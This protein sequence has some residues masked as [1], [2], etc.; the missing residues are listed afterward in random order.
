VTVHYGQRYFTAKE[1]DAVAVRCKATTVLRMF[2]RWGAAIDA[3]GLV[4]RPYEKPRIDKISEHDLFVELERI[5]KLRGHRPSQ[6][7]WE[8]SSPRLWYTT[9]T[10]R[11]G[12]WRNAC[13]RIIKSKSGLS[14]FAATN[15]SEA[16][17]VPPSAGTADTKAPK[18]RK[19]DIPLRIRLRVI[20]RDG[21]RCVACGRSPAIEAGVSL[22][23]DHVL[24]FVCGGETTLENLQTLCDRCNLGKGASREFHFP[25]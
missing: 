15:S 23:V 20:D 14:S 16:V 18:V 25:R 9:Y 7:E 8:S 1:F 2:G 5:W 19:R 4:L 13:L 22:H 12:G 17:V 3:A 10:K 24:P 6:A 11:F 21:Y